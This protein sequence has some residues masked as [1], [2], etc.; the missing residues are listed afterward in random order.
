[1]NGAV[2]AANGINTAASGIGSKSSED[3]DMTPADELPPEAPIP[4]AD[5][6]NPI[7]TQAC[8]V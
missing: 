6:G 3:V 5:A 7:M 4:F 1:M 2:G 8:T